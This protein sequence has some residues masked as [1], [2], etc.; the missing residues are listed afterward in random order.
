MGLKD[1]FTKEGRRD[2]NIRKCV[3]K[4]K[5]KKIKPDDR[6]PALYTLYEEAVAWVEAIHAVETAPDDGD[7]CAR[8]EEQKAY[9]EMSVAG[10][11]SRLTF[12]YDTNMVRD[13]EEK[14]NVYEW[15]VG[16]GLP[17]LPVIRKHLRISPTLSW[18]LRLVS[19]IC[20]RDT[21]W[22]VLAEVLE[23]FDP[24][25]ERDPS[26]KIQLMTFLGDFKDK[27]GARAMLPFLEDQDETVRYV[28]ADSLFKLGDELARE[29]LLELLTNDEE[30]SLR[31]K[32]SIVEGFERSDWRVKGFKGK[33]EKL[34]ANQLPD[35][36][37]DGKGHIK[38]KKARK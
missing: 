13:E 1:L 38:L 36:V 8:L 12:I 32:A 30:E 31:I 26:R 3:V 21:T 33:V 17:I 27:R 11:L 23:E 15:L 37:V 18:G 28:V 20:D 14:D 19:E 7:A 29:K 22:E 34:L 2:R 6:G 16:L 24:E 5:D 25:Y 4:A 9:G 10:M 35:Y